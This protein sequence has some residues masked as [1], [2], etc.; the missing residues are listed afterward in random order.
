[1][2]SAGSDT[3]RFTIEVTAV[4]APPAISVIRNQSF[5]VMYGENCRVHYALTGDEPIY[6]TIYAM[7]AS[8]APVS[9]FFS[10]DP[11]SNTVSSSNRLEPGVYT[12]ILTATNSAG[13]SNDSFTLVVESVRPNAGP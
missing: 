5:T 7:D 4:L 12:A 9:D 8:G 10:V 11:N 6:V 3:D 1:M 2:N 13:T